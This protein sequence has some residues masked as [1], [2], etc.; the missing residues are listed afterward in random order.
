[1]SLPMLLNA[2]MQGAKDQKDV[3]FFGY[4]LIIYCLDGNT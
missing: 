2:T 1:M 3:Q 4:F